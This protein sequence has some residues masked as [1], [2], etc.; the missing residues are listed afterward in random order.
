M[1]KPLTYYA[2]TV[3]GAAEIAWLEIRDQLPGAEFVETLFA[4]DRHGIVVFR[5]GGP[6]R[7]LR[8][9]RTVEDIF[10]L[11]LSVA[12]VSRQY[13]ELFKITDQIAAAPEF[14]VAVDRLMHF[15]REV[16]QGGAPTF[17]VVSRIYGRFPYKVRNLTISIL[18]GIE[19]RYPH[20]QPT[21]QN[22][23]VEIYANMLGSRFL[24]GLRLPQEV[25]GTVSISEPDEGPAIRPSVAAAMIQLT[26]PAETDVFLDPTCRDG[27][28]L[29]ARRLSGPYQQLLGGDITLDNAQRTRRNLHRQRKE[30][31]S[32]LTISQFEAVAMPFAD[33]TIN[34]MIGYFPQQQLPATELSN[35]LAEMARVLQPGGRAIIFSYDYEQI[36][37]VI[38]QY[39]SLIIQTGYSIAPSR[40][41]WGRIY[42]IEQSA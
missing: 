39:D 33:H 14:K 13:S 23:R 7:A 10:V 30:R 16:N 8:Q 34:K 35:Y 18:K 2:H 29:Q 3:P 31:P 17:Q 20:W 19:K 28:L 37:D 11:A 24:C 22:P 1:A 27:L 32:A 36:K 38:R 25:L 6:I 26:E 4:Q 12:D 42:I 40:K 41:K 9:L 5:Y 21:Q 15:Q